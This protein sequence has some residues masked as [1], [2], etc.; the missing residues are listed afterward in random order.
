MAEVLGP[1]TLLDHALP[2]GWDATRITQ[3]ALRDGVTYGELANILA[4]ALGDLNEQL[5]ADWGWCFF[6]T[7]EIA[8]EYENGGS[9][10]EMP[11]ISDQ[12]KPEPLKGTTIGHMIDLKAYGQGVGGS[13]RY[14]RDAR[15][16]KVMAAISAIVSRGQ[17]RFEKKLLERWFTNTENNV[18]SAGYDVPFVR[19]TGGNVDFAP[20]AYDGEA[21]TTSHNHYL[22]VDSDT[23]DEDDVLN[24]LAE[25]LSEH[26]HNPPYTALIA[27]ADIASYRALTNWVEVVDTV[28]GVAV[29]S[30]QG[31]S[32][33]A[34]YVTAGQRPLGLA[35]YYQGDYGLI[36][37]RYTARVPTGYA[38][39]TKSYG[40][41]NGRNGLAVRVHPQV[42]FGAMIVPET[43]LDDD[44]PIKQI[45]VEFEFGISV[46]NDRTNGAAAYLDSSGSWSNPTIS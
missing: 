35:G 36:E 44:Y 19:G 3:W 41:L 20:P 43:T 26:G 21:F 42:G 24:N 18:G 22:G 5:V 28:N 11:E 45:D 8:M 32:T 31:G 46:G 10:T 9:V 27:R 29:Q 16:A 4:L 34:R 13:K 14:F 23:L 15:S 37:V 39:M 33:G 17:W 30:D 2:T 7:E 1:Q 25:T 38:G 6:L 40:N 12:G